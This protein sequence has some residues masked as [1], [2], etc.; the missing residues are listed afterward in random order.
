MSL[1]DLV[2][3][4]SDALKADHQ[5]VLDAVKTPLAGAVKYARAEIP[6]IEAELATADRWVA[7]NIACIDW[8][9]LGAQPKAIAELLHA[10]EAYRGNPQVLRDAIK[11]FDR[12][13][14]TQCWGNRRDGL[15]D[16]N[17]AASIRGEIGLRLGVAR[18]SAG[19]LRN[20]LVR[21]KM[22]MDSLEGQLLS[23]S[24]DGGAP[25]EPVPL[26]EPPKPKSSGIK[27]DDNFEI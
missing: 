3:Q 9:A 20:I 25:A 18:G 27:I 26:A 8:K 23:W 24:A 7:D 6:I 1:K 4:K 13:T 21:L 14:W 22:A 17:C 12:L 5:A 15:K 19:A 10:L 11:D 2:N 16:L